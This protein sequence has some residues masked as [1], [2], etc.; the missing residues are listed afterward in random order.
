[1]VLHWRGRAHGAVAVSD[2]VVII[3]SLYHD[4]E[5]NNWIPV[6]PITVDLYNT[7]KIITLSVNVL[8]VFTWRTCIQR[9]A[10]QV[11][12]LLALLTGTLLRNDSNY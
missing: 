3:L 5:A 8:T 4:S 1:M 11:E 7:T 9:V 6:C 12:L 2:L 10:K